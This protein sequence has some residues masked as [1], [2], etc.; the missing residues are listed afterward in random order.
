MY[1]LNQIPLDNGSGDQTLTCLLCAV[2]RLDCGEIIVAVRPYWQRTMMIFILCARRK[3]EQPST[4][5]GNT[6]RGTE[7]A[8]SSGPPTKSL[9]SPT[10]WHGCANTPPPHCNILLETGRT[11]V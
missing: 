6:D 2:A 4:D 5:T 9:I 8:K 11:T 1:S 3:A 7:P 10:Y